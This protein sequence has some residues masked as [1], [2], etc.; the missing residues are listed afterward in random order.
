MSTTPSSPELTEILSQ[1]TGA[2]F[3]RADLHIHSFGGSHDVSDASMTPSAIVN[4]AISDGLDVIAI[5]DHNEIRNVSEAIAV[6]KGKDLVVIAGVELSTLQGHLLCYFATFEQLQTFF[7]RL[8]FQDGGLPTSRCNESIPKCLDLV[9][10]LGGF[11]VLAHVDA[12]SGFET[13]NPGGSPHKYD[14]ICHQ[15]LLGIE[16]K[17]VSSPISYSSSDPDPDRKLMGQKRIESLG[18][19]VKQYLARV[20]NS[21]AHTLKALGRNA[22]DLKRVTRI[23][24]DT[25]S[26][27]SLKIAFADADA[28]VRIEDLVPEAIPRILGFKADGGFLNNLSIQFSPNL[29]CIIGG[30]GT[31]KSTTFESIRCL[32]HGNSDSKVVDSEVWADNLHLWVAQVC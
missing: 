9:K 25:P 12:G 29:N 26:F 22:E 18:L 16:L 14:V 1:S 4:T 30:R 15:A 3:F 32:A 2:K 19:G 5:T 24:M 11:S 21:D 10:E 23:K 31:G 6:S 17:H 28:R 8:T 20:M 13:D 7:G 27:E